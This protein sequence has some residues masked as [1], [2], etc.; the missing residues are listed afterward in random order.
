MANVTFTSP[1]MKKDVT[2]YAVAG[3]RR[4]ILYLAKKHKIPIPFECEDGECGSCL[5]EV[6]PLGAK[7]FMAVDL[8]EKEKATLLANG[9]ISKAQI[10]DAEVKDIPPPYRLECQYIVR[11][12]DILVRFSGEPG[13]A[14]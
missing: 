4:N 3:D 12:E 6:T 9:K 11:D 10:A 7:P 1:I 13:V 5:V 14:A 2:V 8:T